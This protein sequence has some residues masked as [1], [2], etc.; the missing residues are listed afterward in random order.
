M[1]VPVADPTRPAALVVE[2]HPLFRDALTHLVRTTL[3]ALVPAAASSAE[4][5]LELAAVLSDVRLVLLDPGLPGLDGAEAISAFCRAC[6][7]A[8]LLAVSASE[9]RREAMAALRAG[10]KVF[11]SKA[12]STEVLGQALLRVAAGEVK[13]PEWITPQGRA[14]HRFQEHVDNLVIDSD[15]LTG[16]AGQDLLVGGTLIS[17]SILID[18]TPDNRNWC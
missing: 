5:G 16:G 9:D 1:R 14:K 15:T 8:G 2:D 11:V 3:P 13:R 12:V 6:P 4:E 7:A 17:A 10:A 18:V